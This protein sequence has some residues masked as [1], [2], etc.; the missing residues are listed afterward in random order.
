ME[1]DTSPVFLTVKLCAG[2]VL[3]I[4]CV[5]NVR[6][7]GVKVSVRVKP[8][9]L[10]GTLCGLPVASSATLRL[11]VRVPFA[12]G[13]NAIDTAQLLP[14]VSVTGQVLVVTA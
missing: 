13:L 3:P 2:L 5:A 8:L 10:S 11:A 12:V 6:L 4:F 1:V 14:A 7:D 9:P